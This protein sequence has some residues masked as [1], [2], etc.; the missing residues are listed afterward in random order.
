MTSRQLLIG[1]ALVLACTAA[2]AQTQSFRCKNDLVNVGDSK[3][4]VLNKCGEPVSRDSFC[5]PVQA[6]AAASP[7]GTVV[8]VESCQNVDDW[9]YNPGRGQ[10]MTS[11]QFEAGKLVSIKYG[12][13]VN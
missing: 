8:Q 1:S 7:N 9:T 10:F 13:R 5:K 3:S 4:S 11:L 12:E 6:P 2:S